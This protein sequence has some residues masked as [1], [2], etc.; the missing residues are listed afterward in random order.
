MDN[1]SSDPSTQVLVWDC[2]GDKR[3]K[4]PIG[5]LYDKVGKAVPLSILEALIKNR[6][7]PRM[8][9]RSPSLRKAA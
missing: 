5:E 3:L 8:S 2:S 4:M 7:D 6:Q 1:E 9:S